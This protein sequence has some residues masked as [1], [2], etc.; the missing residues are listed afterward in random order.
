MNDG[1]KVRNNFQTPSRIAQIRPNVGRHRTRTDFRFLFR[2][3]DTNVRGHERRRIYGA[4]HARPEIIP[5]AGKSA[6]RPKQIYG[7]LEIMPRREEAAAA[8]SDGSPVSFTRTNVRNSP[9]LLPPLPQIGAEQSRAELAAAWER[10]SDRA[11]DWT[12]DSI[13]FFSR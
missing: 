7:T 5:R 1:G 10:N 13:Y 6:S 4:D 8:R 9:V 11:A 3:R 12:L 2:V